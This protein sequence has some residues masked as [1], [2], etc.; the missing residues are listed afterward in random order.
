MIRAIKLGLWEQ[1]T[2]PCIVVF[3]FLGIS[4]DALPVVKGSRQI[5]GELAWLRKRLLILRVTV[6]GHFW[7]GILL[8]GHC[9]GS[10]AAWC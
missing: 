4:W 5:R 10:R 2:L 1:L 7:L 8:V 3:C 9:D 6:M